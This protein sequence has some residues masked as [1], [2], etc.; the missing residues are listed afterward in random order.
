MSG[1]AAPA[2]VA[3]SPLLARAVT[4]FFP[5]ASASRAALVCAAAPAP[6]ASVP[7]SD[8]GCD[9][10]SSAVTARTIV[11]LVAHGTLCTVGEDGGPLG[12]REMENWV[13]LR[14]AASLSRG[15]ASGGLKRGSCAPSAL[16]QVVLGM[17]SGRGEG[18]A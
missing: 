13:R 8:A 6:S 7:A 11:D 10:P 15:G 9:P 2:R 14:W 4:S 1:A 12:K 3:P 18:A 5:P 16:L 17:I